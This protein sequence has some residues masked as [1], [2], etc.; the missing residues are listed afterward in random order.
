ME[1]A[2]GSPS[3]IMC[4]PAAS[5]GAPGESCT[6]LRESKQHNHG[7][8]PE[9]ASGCRETQISAHPVSAGRVW[10]GAAAEE[11]E[12]LGLAARRTR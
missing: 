1:V 4:S 10:Q 8:L 5:D 3:G 7:P 2:A 11:H 6:V 9:T 12:N